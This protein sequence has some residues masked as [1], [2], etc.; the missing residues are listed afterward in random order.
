MEDEDAL[1]RKR[2][3]F[4]LR[5]ARE[6]KGLN[7]GGAAQLVGLKSK[8]AISDYESGDTPVPQA[9]LRR[10]AKE[11]GWDLAIFTEPDPTAEEQALERMSRSARSAIRVAGLRASEEA[12][13]AT[14]GAAGERGELRRTQP[15]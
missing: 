13:E 11:Y 15:A 10:M 1:F 2:Q 14:R 9:R 7:Q 4:W 12:E 3:G 6:S 8:S 5:M